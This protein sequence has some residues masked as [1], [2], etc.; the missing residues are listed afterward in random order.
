MVVILRA[1]LAMMTIYWRVAVAP[2]ESV[3]AMVNGKL[4]AAVGVPVIVPDDGPSVNPPG[5][6]P[7]LT[8]YVNAPVPPL[9][10]TPVEYVVLSTPF[11][12]VVG[13]SDGAALIMTENC[14]VAVVVPASVACT[15]NV[16]VAAV[17]GLPFR[18][19]FPCRSVT[20][21]GNEPAEIPHV[22]GDAPPE[23]RIVWL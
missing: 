6:A 7:W 8:E 1:E 17:V 20:P 5:S 18:V 13:P 21:G 16:Y 19:A 23:V 9:A 2:T 15:V 4:P 11:G 10:C 22:K 14:F 3:A 12:S